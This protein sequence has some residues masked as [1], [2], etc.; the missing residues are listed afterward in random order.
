MERLL[1]TFPSASSQ[2]ALSRQVYE[3]AGLDPL[4]TRSVEFH[5]I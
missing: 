4:D 3:Q 1:V 2:E 5:E